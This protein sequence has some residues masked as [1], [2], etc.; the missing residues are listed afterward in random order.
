M[1]SELKVFQIFKAGRH[2][3]MKGLSIE[4]TERDLHTMAAVYQPSIG[5]AALCLGHPANDLPAYGS[6]AGLFVKGDRLYAQAQPDADLTKMV[7]QA[8]YRHVSASFHHP[9]HPNNPKPGTYYLRHVGFLGA[10]PPSVKGLQ[11]PEFAEPA[12]AICF[13]EGYQQ[14][15][16]L[17]ETLTLLRSGVDLECDREALHRLTLAHQGDY[18]ELSYSE[19]LE[20]VRGIQNTYRAGVTLDQGRL[21]MHNAALN[22]QAACPDMSYAEAIQHAAHILTF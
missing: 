7:R 4:F 10:M 5:K 1:T 9:A 14:Q 15:D 22:H 21:A 16:G 8:S 11:R 12:G 20:E 18:P 3:T 17:A 19:A 13:S 6:V 2:T